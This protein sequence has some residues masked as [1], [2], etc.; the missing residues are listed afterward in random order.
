MR[1]PHE[2]RHLV[3]A[4]AATCLFQN[5]TCNL[6]TLAAF[7]RGGEELERAIEHPFGWLRRGEQE[8][9]QTSKVV[10]WHGISLGDRCAELLERVARGRIT[11]GDGR[12]HGARA[13]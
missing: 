3:E 6:D 13:R 1:R 9:P 12:Q 4:R 8:A 10:A 5:A 2:D 7:A 11:C